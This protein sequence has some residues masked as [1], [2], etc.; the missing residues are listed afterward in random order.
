M[1]SLPL[2]LAARE[3]VRLLLVLL[4]LLVM[5]LLVELVLLLLLLP[6]VL[7]DAPSGEK[8]LKKS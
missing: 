4:L 2:D 5:L 8:N 6:G 7:P 3:V 1:T